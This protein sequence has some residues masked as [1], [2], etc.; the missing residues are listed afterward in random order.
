MPTGVYK[1]NPKPLKERFFEKLPPESERH[2]DKCWEWR[3]YCNK[4][5]GYGRIGSGVKSVG[6][7]LARRVAWQFANDQEIP[8][9]MQVNHHCDNRPCVNPDHLCLGTHADNMR[10]MAERGRGTC[11]ESQHSVTVP[12]WIVRETLKFLKTG[13]SQRRV[14]R[15]LTDKGFPCN[16]STVSRWAR[17]KKR[18]NVT[19]AEAAAL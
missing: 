14:A 18:K 10:D 3:A 15:M 8:D 19:S 11:G 17:G 7:L 16:Q 5:D 4:R 13:V 1:R 9:G 2:P 12:D 6:M